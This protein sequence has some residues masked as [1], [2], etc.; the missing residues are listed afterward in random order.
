MYI[1]CFDK[2][3]CILCR[4]LTPLV[5]GVQTKELIYEAIKYSS[6]KKLSHY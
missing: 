6:V 4:K 2:H 3:F 5:A 1:V